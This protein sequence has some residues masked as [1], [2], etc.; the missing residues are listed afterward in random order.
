VA[1]GDFERLTPEAIDQVWVRLQAG[2]P[3]KPTARE[4]GLCASTV[5]EYLERCG[6]IR[7]EPTASSFAPESDAKVWPR[8]TG[9]QYWHMDR[10]HSAA[11]ATGD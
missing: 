7:K 6:G 11:R 1:H 2:Q 8:A 4:P 5:R 3:A 10:M 9:R